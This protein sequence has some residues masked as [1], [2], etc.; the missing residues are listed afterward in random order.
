M[1]GSGIFWVPRGKECP[2]GPT[3]GWVS[4]KGLLTV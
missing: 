2:E 3:G 4:L 1:D